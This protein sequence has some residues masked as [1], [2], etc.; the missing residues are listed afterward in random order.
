MAQNAEILAGRYRLGRLLGQGGMSDVYE[1]AD[2]RSGTAVAVKIVRSEDPDL[3]RRLAQEA[4][5]L[6]RLEHPGLVRLLDTGFTGSRAYLVMELIAGSTLAASLRTGALGPESAA[7]LGAQL[8]DALAYVHDRGIVH[9]DVK[10]SNILLPPAGDARLGDFGIARLLDASTLTVAGTTLGTAAYM[11]PEQLEVH[12]VGPS[13]DIWSLGMVLLECLT[14]RRVYAGLP[15]RSRGAAPRWTGAPSRR[16][17][18]RLE[19]RLG[20]H[21]GSPA[22]PAPHGRRGGGSPRHFTIPRSVG[23]RHGPRD[24][25]TRPDGASRL[26]RSS[27]RTQVRRMFLALRAPRVAISAHTAQPVRFHGVPSQQ[28]VSR[29]RLGQGLPT[30]ADCCHRLL[31]GVWPHQTLRGSPG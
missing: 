20:R 3:A 5:A 12:H 21:A 16:P 1:A 15:R 9:R 31:P 27:P 30:I 14:G 28:S 26:D 11:A 25:S 22:R 17:P 6:E 10:P 7:A 29:S 13:V 8:A 19:A 2:E 18:G 24:R 4:Q 23:S